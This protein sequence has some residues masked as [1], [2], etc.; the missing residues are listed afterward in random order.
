LELDCKNLNI[1]SSIVDYFQWYLEHH[2][3]IFCFLEVYLFYSRI[4]D[5]IQNHR[6]SLPP[7]VRM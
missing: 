2:Q 7:V 4:H 5:S 1:T 3:K 6:T